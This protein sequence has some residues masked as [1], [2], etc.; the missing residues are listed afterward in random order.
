[1]AAL[2]SL[3]NECDK[4]LQVLRSSP[5]ITV[6]DLILFVLVAFK[7]IQVIR[8]V[9][10]SYVKSMSENVFLEPRRKM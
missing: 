7:K 1:L 6:Q 4:F 10:P 8:R 2:C 3:L 9:S 5:N